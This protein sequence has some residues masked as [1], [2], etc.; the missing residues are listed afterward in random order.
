MT[1][2]NVCSEK[3]YLKIS[4]EHNESCLWDFSCLSLYCFEKSS[5]YNMVQLIAINLITCNG[6]K[7]INL[8][9]F[10]YRNFLLLRRD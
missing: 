4:K 10:C 5:L 6:I 8:M 7:N 3:I 2:Q 1:S 9:L